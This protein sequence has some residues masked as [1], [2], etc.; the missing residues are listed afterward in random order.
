MFATSTSVIEE[1]YKGDFKR[2]NHYIEEYNEIHSKSKR[3]DIGFCKEVLAYAEKSNNVLTLLFPVD[4]TDSNYLF[5][6]N[7]YLNIFN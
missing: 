4:I 3:G 6:F 1:E 2:H 7:H 5:R